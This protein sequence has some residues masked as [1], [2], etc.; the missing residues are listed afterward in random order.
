MVTFD[1]ETF[2][3]VNVLKKNGFLFDVKGFFE[4]I[5]ETSK[6]KLIPNHIYAFFKKAELYEEDKEVVDWI[7]PFDD[8]RIESIPEDYLN[9]PFVNLVSQN[10]ISTKFQRFT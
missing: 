7:I 6:L 2:V 9:L 8:E 1:G 4:K 5:P 3:D 10:Y